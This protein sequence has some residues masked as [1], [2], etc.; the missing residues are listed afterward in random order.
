MNRRWRNLTARARQRR[1]DPPFVGVAPVTPV[2]P[3]GRIGNNPKR[4]WSPRRGDYFTVLQGVVAGIGP[5]MPKLVRQTRR[6]QIPVRRGAFHSMPWPPAGAAPG[7]VPRQGRRPSTRA[8]LVR[9]GRF[10]LVVAGLP[11]TV[12]PLAPTLLRQSA[13]RAVV[14]R[15][16]AFLATPLVGAVVVVTTRGQMSPTDRAAPAMTPGTGTAAAMSPTH[17]TTATMGG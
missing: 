1:F 10:T 4:V 5:L 12:G 16:G 3:P 13:R 6:P 2:P 14:L 11:L 15:R 8:H 9:R 7:F 17:R